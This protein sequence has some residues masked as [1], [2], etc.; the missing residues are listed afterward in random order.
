MTQGE[1][2]LRGLFYR[3]SVTCSTV[4]SLHALSGAVPRGNSAKVPFSR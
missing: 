3:G 2:R 4:L 1:T